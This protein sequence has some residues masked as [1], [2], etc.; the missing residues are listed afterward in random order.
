MYYNIL[1]IEDSKLVSK[2]LEKKF[3]AAQQTCSVTRTFLE[4]S[5][6][7]KVEKF[8]FIILDLNLPDAYGEELLDSVQKLSDAKIFVLTIEKDLELRE[9]LYK[10]GILDYLVK[11]KYFDNSVASMLKVMRQIEMNKEINILFIDDSRFMREQIKKILLIRN[12]NVFTAENVSIG[13]E[14]INKHDINLIILDMELPDGNGI[15]VLRELKFNPKYENVPVLILSGT[16]AQETVRECLKL[17]AYD[18]IKKPFNIEEFTL[19]V[20]LGVSLERKTTLLQNDKKEI[21]SE[22]NERNLLTQEYQDAINKSNIL[23]RVDVAY[24]ITEVN[25]KFCEISGYS[26]SECI[27]KT[28]L[29]LS[30]ISDIT[31]KHILEETATGNIWTGKI[32]NKRKSGEIYYTET[33]IMPILDINNKIIEYLW[34]SSDITE[35]M[36]FHYEIEDTQKEMIYKMGEIAESRSE[37]TGFHVRRVAECCKQL[38]LLYGL[39]DDSAYILYYA[40][41]MHDIG[42]VAIPDNILKK[43]EKLTSYEWKV[44]KTHT[45]IGYYLFKEAKRPILQAAAIVAHE[46]HEKYDGSGYPLGLKGDKI[47]IYARIL[48]IADVFDAL[49]SVRVY[50]KAWNIDDVKTLFQNEKGKHFDPKITQIFL[51]NFDQFIAIRDKYPDVLE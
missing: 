30:K 42:K 39:E 13:F 7:L 44:M 38:A 28:Y 49:L 35:I 27:D 48:A 46:H 15:D 37:E 45:T 26:I 8:D 40:S 50:K 34:M 6:L 32:T 21:I 16:T 4:A 24:K 23:V 25:E 43:P 29:E 47:H 11:D 12:Y 10:D 22:L 1:I 17:G 20:D 5:D 41:P 18:V 2:I 14:L 51:D 36:S 33:T 3:T 9:A 19:K 31:Y